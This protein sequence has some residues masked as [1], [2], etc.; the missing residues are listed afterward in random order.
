MT[1]GVSLGPAGAALRLV[2]PVALALLAGGA[3]LAAVGVDPLAYYAH[4][5]RRGMLTWLGLQETL[6]RM[7][8]LL[9]L[10][11]SLIVAFRAG[12]WNLGV[13][14]Q[15]L[16]AAVAVAAAAPLLAEH[17]PGGLMLA[18]GFALA[19][20]VGAAWSLVPALLKAYRQVNEIITTLMMTFLGVG[21]ANTLVK[22]A[23]RDPGTTVAQTR[24]LAVEDR[25][26][27]L[28]DTIVTGGLPIA[29]VVVVVVHLLVTRTAWGMRLRVVGAS[30]KAAL[31]AGLAVP[32]LTV[33]AFAVSGGLAGAAAAIEVLGVRGLVQADWNP[34]YGLTVI[35]FVFLARFNG[36]AVIAFTF[37]FSMLS[38]GGESASRRFGVPPYYILVLVGLLLVFLA[39]VDHLGERRRKAAA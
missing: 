16:L 5:V 30:P 6:T 27:R 8:P 38:I 23:F 15:F 3:L 39:L 13:D 11:A 35:P 20:A 9:V 18:A 1:E 28:F 10:G 17:L 37:L 21:L 25:L 22:L 14:G 26:P 4:V 31:H 36:F 12:V 2:L 29:L 34:A 7:A 32:G 24:T 19:A 33:A